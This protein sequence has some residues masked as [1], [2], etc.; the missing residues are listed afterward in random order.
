ML[1]KTCVSF[2]PFTAVFTMNIGLRAIGL[3]KHVVDRIDMA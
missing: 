3:R 2:V 1:N